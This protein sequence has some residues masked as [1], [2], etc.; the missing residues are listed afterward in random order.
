[1]QVSAEPEA[2]GGAGDSTAAKLCPNC[3]RFLTK[4]KADSDL[5]FQVERC[6]AC[7]GFWLDA[8][9]WGRLKGR[10][11]AERLHFVFTREWQDRVARAARE[12]GEEEVLRKK[13][14][15]ETWDEIRRVKHWL[16][17][18]PKRGELMAYLMR[19]RG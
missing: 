18:H 7:G 11:L 8:G 3:G 17:G 2:P 6:A 15:D 13:L 4:A 9:E 12:R 14:G 19:D 5:A 16:D 1:V 10:G